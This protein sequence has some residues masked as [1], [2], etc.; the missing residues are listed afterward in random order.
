MTPLLP[1]N[2]FWSGRKSTG[3]F[4][5]GTDKDLGEVQDTSSQRPYHSVPAALNQAY[6]AYLVSAKN[7]RE[8]S[9]S[10]L[11]ESLRQVFH[12]LRVRLVFTSVAP[13]KCPTAVTKPHI[14]NT[15]RCHGQHGLKDVEQTIDSNPLRVRWH[16]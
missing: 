9:L 5:R 10:A 3:D 15:F 16:L 6:G 4:K 2:V 7:L 11:S 14:G 13:V 8:K 12:Q 1:K